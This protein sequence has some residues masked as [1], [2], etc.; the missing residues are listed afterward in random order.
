M[1]LIVTR[2]IYIKY[3]SLLIVAVLAFMPCMEMH[4]QSATTDITKPTR[5]RVKDNKS[6]K[7]EV[8]QDAAS[9]KKQETA[10]ENGCLV[11]N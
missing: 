3:I 5:E 11:I 1:D 10:P 4:A 9:A 2:K 7:Q 6:S 8:K